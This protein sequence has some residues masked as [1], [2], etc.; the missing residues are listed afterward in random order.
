MKK[1]DWEILYSS[2]NRIELNALALL[3]AETGDRILRDQDF[4]ALHTLACRKADRNLP[5]KNAV[6]IGTL[7]GNP[8]LRSFIREDEIPPHGFRIRTAVNPEH[9]DKQLLLIAGAG[10][11]EVLYG[12]TT[13]L[14]DMIPSLLPKDGDGVRSICGLF[15]EPFPDMDFAD[16]PQTLVRSVFTWGHPIGAYREYFK[17]LARL[18]FNRVYLWNEY[19]PVNAA[20]VM[21]E[22]HGWGIEVFWGFAWGWSTCCGQTDLNNLEG[23]SDA[24]VNE[25]RTVWSRLPGDGIYFQSFTELKA[26][27]IGGHS[28]AESVTELVNMTASRILAERP[29]QKIVYGLHALSVRDRIDIIAGTDSRLEILWEDCGGFPYRIN[30]PD[31]GERDWRFTR[32]LLAQGRSMGLVFKCQLVQKWA[33]FAHQS[34][35]YI[36]GRNGA[37]MMCHDIAVTTP[38]WRFYDALWLEK[39]LTAWE[40]AKMIH[41]EG[42]LR[43]EMNL[44]AQLNG[45]VRLPTALTAELFWSTAVPYSE[46]LRKIILRSYVSL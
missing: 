40:L 22:A 23:L 1:R 36:E 6:I 7:K 35:P 39:G 17:N 44:A 25:W 14:D 24:I 41:D 3:Y 42:G 29:D 13:F 31:D 20:E 19:P 8:I 45:P 5:E 37:G 12:V 46:I 21:E 33:D 34:G 32:A 38:L 43:V 18:K 9:T 11:S 2:T 30:I 28:V 16:A 15:Q 10:S 4:Y 27:R 26:D